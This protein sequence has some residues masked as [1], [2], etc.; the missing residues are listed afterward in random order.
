[1]KKKHQPKFNCLFHHDRFFSDDIHLN[2]SIYDVHL[3]LSLSNEQKDDYKHNKNY[4]DILA[5]IYLG[6][7]LGITE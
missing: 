1:M 4:V 2:L 5:K 6:T 3:N 7:C